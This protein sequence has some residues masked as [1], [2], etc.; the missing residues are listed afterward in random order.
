MSTD[1]EHIHPR[2]ATLSSTLS[3]QSMHHEHGHWHCWMIKMQVNNEGIKNNQPINQFGLICHIVFLKLYLKVG[4][5]MQSKELEE[6]VEA[7]MMRSC[8]QQY[9]TTSTRTKT[10]TPHTAGDGTGNNSCCHAWGV[11]KAT[12]LAFNVLVLLPSES[13]PST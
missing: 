1:D 9:T 3:T 8:S 6:L 5:W 11:T 13:L 12:L 10:M 2:K 7:Q 4:W